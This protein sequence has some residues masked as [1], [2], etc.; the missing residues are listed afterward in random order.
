MAAR[1]LSAVGKNKLEK[2]LY[3]LW[4][5]VDGEALEIFREDPVWFASSK[6]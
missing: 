6:I 4:V 2:L 5:F 3:L 1:N